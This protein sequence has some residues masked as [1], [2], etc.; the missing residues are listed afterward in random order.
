MIRNNDATELCI[1]KGQEGI[2]V[3]WDAIEGPHGKLVL[4]TVYIELTNPP[5]SVQF[6]G[7]PPNV[8]PIPR[9]TTDVTCRLPNDTEITIQREQVVILP[10]FAMTDYSSQGKTRPNNVVDPGR[11]KNHQSYYTALSRSSSAVG[12][13][14]VQPFSDKKITGGIS[15]YLRQEFRELEILN[16]ITIKAYEG[17]LPDSVKGRLRNVLIST[18]QKCTEYKH[19][20][21]LGWHPA[22]QW[23][24]HETQVQTENEDGFWSEELNAAM[25]IYKFEKKNNTNG[26]KGSTKMHAVVESEPTVSPSEKVKGKK[27]EIVHQPKMKKFKSSSDPITDKEPLGLKWDSENFS[28]GYDSFFTIIYNIWRDNM[29]CISQDL[30]GYSDLMNILCKKFEKVNQKVLT[31]EDAHDHIRMFL[32]RSNA[33]IFPMGKKGMMVSSLIQKLMGDTTFGSISNICD[34]CGSVHSVGLGGFHILN[35]EG[36]D[37]LD[38]GTL[39]GAERS[40]KY[41]QQWC[42]NCCKV[43][44]ITRKT[45]LDEIPCMIALEEYLMCNCA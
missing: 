43:V 9:T 35:S 16:T 38:V 3:G 4:Q 13:L 28:C 37:R 15:G 8:V 23:R 41:G 26:K 7:L 21:D 33:Q 34:A 30:S 19:E 12:T 45:F 24:P 32:H 36:A 2:C 29:T 6:Q 27:A 22:L 10:N 11:C 40:Q 20:R 5:Q 25:A 42:S 17:R 18:Y 39:L 31:F 44:S 1:T 14:L